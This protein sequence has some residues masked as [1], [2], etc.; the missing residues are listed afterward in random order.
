M[1]GPFVHNIDPIYGKIGPFYLWFY[2]TSFTVGF[3]GVF[4][5]LKRA[6]K[7][8]EMSLNEVYSLSLFLAIGVLLFGRLVEVIF[9]EWEYYGSHLL[10]IPAVWLGGMSTHGI[11]LGGIIGIVVFCRVYRKSFLSI[12]DVLAIAGAY[13]MGMGRIGNFIDGQ[14]VGSVTDLW[15]AV[16]FPDAEGFRH[17]VVLYDG[18]KN[19]M[20]IPF[21]LLI[22]SFNPP[23]GIILAHFLLWYG[24]LR[25]PID[26]FREYRTELYGFPP[27]QEFNLLMTALGIGMLF[28]FYRK[29]KQTKDDIIPFVSTGPQRIESSRMLQAKRVVFIV[30]LLIPTI[31]P[32]DWTQDVPKRYGKR[33][34]G[35]NYSKLYPNIETPNTANPSNETE[36]N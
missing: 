29:A 2:G 13:I 27:G 17:P 26:F 31:I 6:R 23:R 14:I 10:H 33:H 28:W 8:L 16:K 3:I 19:I 7:Q 4:F 20:L 25:I 9:Y 35:L 5:W 11:L 36:T 22:R 21:L 24:F 1:L 30:L 34:E 15:W 12:A 32:S 18:I